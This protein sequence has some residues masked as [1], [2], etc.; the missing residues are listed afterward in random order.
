MT[1]Q[2]YVSRRVLVHQ[3]FDFCENLFRSLLV[4]NSKSRMDLDTSRDIRK[5]GRVESHEMEVQ[6]GQNRQP[7]NYSVSGN[8]QCFETEWDIHFVRVCAL[9][10]YHYRRLG[11]PISNIN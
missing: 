5:E 9:V 3:S 1:Y 2:D 8:C 6:V 10:S 11:R 7:E 4:L